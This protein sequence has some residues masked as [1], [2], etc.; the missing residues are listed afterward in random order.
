M[1][2]SRGTVATVEVLRLAS[3][4]DAIAKFPTGMTVFLDRG[5]PGDRVE[6]TV[7]EVR[8]RFA[9][10]HVL[11]WVEEGP[12]RAASGCAVS[13][14]CGGCR[15][16][17]TR[18]ADELTLKVDSLSQNM[19]RLARDIEW[20]TPAVFGSPS[21]EG[22]RERARFR[23][24]Q[25]GRTGFLAASSDELVVSER[26]PVVHPSIDAA[27]AVIGPVLADLEG[28]T[29]V[30][31][32]R[33]RVRGGA[34]VTIAFT[35]DHY[36]EALRTM[37]ARLE[38][39][40]PMHDV[41][42]VATRTSRRVKGVI[43]DAKVIRERKV[44]DRVVSVFDGVGAFSQANASLNEILVAHVAELVGSMPNEGAPVLDLF[45]GS[46]NLTFP[47]L[48]LGGAVTGVEAAPPAVE[49]ARAAWDELLEKE[50][51][52]AGLEA[53]AHRSAQPQLR[54]LCHDLAAGLPEA[55]ADV[56][57][58][59]AVVLDPP[60]EGIS[61]RLLRAVAALGAPVVYVSCDPPAFARDAS[62]FAEL[63]YRLE[64]WAAFDMYAR[65]AHIEIVALLI[66]PD[67]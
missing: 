16:Q 7:T 35:P 48:A 45:C 31:I 40:K 28:V 10:A 6:V 34:A 13:D 36:V 42:T 63:G 41:T 49:A 32:E 5:L 9:R 56:P 33:D 64:R 38:R 29:D 55:T 44:G 14:R 65:T 26:C 20:P 23:V 37:P 19:A 53:S 62:R 27:R 12:L 25:R 66:P 4:G 67:Q 30:F 18:Y 15:F 59:R 11:S 3:G 17:S 43:G 24:D 47:L 61:P 58:W 2:V 54:F 39:C 51:E 52:A 50:A 60:R 22:Y 21:E 57:N 46:G 1:N 8:K